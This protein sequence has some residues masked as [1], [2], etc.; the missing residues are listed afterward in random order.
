MKDFIDF[1]IN[2]FYVYTARVWNLNQGYSIV[3]IHFSFYE[4]TI[5]RVPAVDRVGV[6]NTL[7]LSELEHYKSLGNKE[8]ITKIPFLKL[9]LGKHTLITG[10]DPS[11]KAY[12]ETVTIYDDLKDY[13]IEIKVVP[14]AVFE[15]FHW[16]YTIFNLYHDC[17]D[18]NRYFMVYDMS[19]GLPL[20]EV[21]HPVEYNLSHD[22]IRELWRTYLKVE[23]EKSKQH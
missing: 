20:T 17:Q 3:E 18:H 13:D 21:P 11:W 1:V 10:E 4:I 19:T 6:K 23:L 15:S 2:V 8:S 16:L 22:E 9:I 7:G 12:P 14:M 5:H